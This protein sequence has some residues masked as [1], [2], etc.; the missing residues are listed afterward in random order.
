MTLVQ[1]ETEVES[2]TFHKSDRLAYLTQTTLSVDETSRI[3]ERLKQR[4]PQIE[5]PP[6]DDICYATQNRQ[7]AIRDLAKETDVV[8]VI[9]S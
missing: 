4:F 9:G 5:G 1:D 6:K 3:V 7:Q 2:L 8:L